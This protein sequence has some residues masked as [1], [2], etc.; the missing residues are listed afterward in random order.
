M[1]Q[2][3]HSKHIMIPLLEKIKVMEPMDINSDFLNSV[4]HENRLNNP[5]GYVRVSI[6][7]LGLPTSLAESN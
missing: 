1:L 7:S 5:G 3:I 4:D 6:K 2:Y